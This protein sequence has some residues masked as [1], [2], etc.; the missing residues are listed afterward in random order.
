MAGRIFRPKGKH[1]W[2]LAFMGPKGG[3]WQEI[4]ESAKTDDEE[5]ARRLLAKR[6]R[7][8]EN[9][10]DGVKDFEGRGS[11]RYTGGDALDALEAHWREK[12]IKGLDQAQYRLKQLRTAFG[13]ARVRAITVER[14]RAYRQSR[15]EVGLAPAS[16]N[17]A[18]EILRT[19]LRLAFKEGKINRVPAFPERLPENNARQG[20]FEQAEIGALLPH[21]PAPLD[22]MVSFAFRTGWRRGELIGLT[23]EMVS[24]EEIRL[25]DSKN[26]EGR[27]LPLTAEL[28]EIV[29]RLRRLREYPRP[30]GTALSTCVFHRNGE[31]INR[32]VFGKQWRR[33]C[34]AA[35]LGTRDERGFYSGR[36]FHDLRR[37]AVRS[38]VRGGVHPTVAMAISGHKSASMF[39]RYNITDDRDKLSALEASREWT[40]KQA[41]SNVVEM[42]RR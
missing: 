14:I 13:S 25:P 3:D 40:E 19:A 37:S 16:V 28:Q 35:G 27:T 32:T 4:R 30:G 2:M 36:I 42:V 1:F 29:N 38:L 33:A 23:W 5:T 7:E 39:Q 18:V 8:V 41:K 15:I 24:K 6:L 22:L 21:L 17:R 10:R 26:G 11:L 9:D 20:F 34:I 12:E 31:P